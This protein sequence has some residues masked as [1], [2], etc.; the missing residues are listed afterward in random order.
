ME[1]YPSFYYDNITISH[2]KTQGAEWMHYV[3][4]LGQHYHID[5]ERHETICSN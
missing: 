5:V 2:Y 3:Q 4:Y 1:I